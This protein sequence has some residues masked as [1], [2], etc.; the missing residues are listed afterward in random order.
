[1]KRIVIPS[2]VAAVALL[3][4][5]TFVRINPGAFSMSSSSGER[6]VG[7][8]D[9]STISYNVPQFTGIDLTINADID[10]TM[11]ADEEASIVVEAPE[12]IIDKLYFEVEDGVLLVRFS[13]DR[14]YSYK[15]INVKAS[16]ATLEK[17]DIRGAG[18]FDAHGGLDCKSLEIEIQGAGDVDMDGVRCDGDLS[19]RVR[20]AGDV[21]LH[22]ISCEEVAVEIMGAGDVS[23]S[24]KAG[25]ADL[26]IKGAGDIDIRHLD[27]TDVDTS[28][29]GIGSIQR[30]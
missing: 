21:D 19:V 18:D 13:D 30:K 14:N 15:E 5:C 3:S 8:K 17:L 7:S 29:A 22:E 4:G 6:V 27:V 23:L 11:S 2:L 12:N 1:M 9:L 10:Y 28:I 26:S 24:G 25:R 16:S 20:G